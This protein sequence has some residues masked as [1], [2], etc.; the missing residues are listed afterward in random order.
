MVVCNTRFQHLDIHIATWLSPVRSTRNQIDHLVI[1]GKHVSNVLDV[2]NIDSDHF[3]VAAKVRLRISASRSVPSSTQRKLD[4]L[5][6]PQS[7]PNDIGGLWV[8]IYHSLRA[9][10]GFEGP[11]KRKQWHDEG[12][13]AASAA[14]NHDYKTN[15]GGEEK[16]RESPY[17]KQE[18]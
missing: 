8:H 14:N 9:S 15:C 1:D 10:V 16:G 11:L 2:P 7:S 5:R 12:C 13:R 6:Q 18:E 3:L 4:K 17:E